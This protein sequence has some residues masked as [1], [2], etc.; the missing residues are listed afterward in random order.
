[1]TCAVFP[2][3]FDPFT[4]GHLDVVRRAASMCDQVLVG[5]AHNAGKSGL[6]TVDQRLEAARAT[7]AGDLALA[8]AKAQVSVEV[9]DGLVVDF[10]QDRGVTAI[11]KGL[12]SGADFDAELP[13]ALMNRQLTGIET[14]F[15]VGDPALS[16]I[17]SSLV[18]DI[19]RHGGSLEGLLAAP[20]AQMVTEAL[21]A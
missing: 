18:K 7:L 6:L 13:M 20:V 21:A 2:G 1:M 17:A 9:I 15:I 12:R 19:A 5:V 3:S 16:H 11:V 10:C 4:L 8:Q 14:V